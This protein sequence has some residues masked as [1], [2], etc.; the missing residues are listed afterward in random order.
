VRISEIS[1]ITLLVVAVAFL[2]SCAATASRKPV[3]PTPT[4]AAPSIRRVLDVLDRQDTAVTT[5][6]GQARLDYSSP[7]QSFK[8][9]QVVVVKA[10]SS[11]RIDVMNPFG[12]SYSVATDGKKLTAYDRRQGVYYQ[13]LAQSESFRKFIG[14]PMGAGDFAAVLRGLPPG[15]GDTR[16]SVVVAAE[17]GWLMRRRLGT[18]GVMELVVDATSL[19]PVRVKMSGDKA[20]HQVDVKYGEYKDVAGVFVPHLIEV[21]FK[22]GSHLGVAYKHVQRGIV[23][24]LDAFLID[25]PAGARVV[26]IDGEDALATVPVQPAGVG[27]GG[28]RK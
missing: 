7:Q 4:G 16:W 28:G 27:A 20:R 12:V 23:L 3:A 15:L 26:N 19:L 5:F 17:G 1:R 14:I 8:S 18:G 9:T 21:K 2:S 22:D 25:R 11:A 10:P 13:G 6:R 24:P